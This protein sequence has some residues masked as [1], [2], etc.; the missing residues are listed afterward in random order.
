MNKTCL[1]CKHFRLS[2]SDSG[3]SEDTPGTDFS[4]ECCKNYW[5]FY[6]GSVS[7]EEMA[8]MLATAETC[9]DYQHHKT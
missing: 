2:N 4:I 7:Q 6:P 1:L 3:Y 8:K 9:S 5:R